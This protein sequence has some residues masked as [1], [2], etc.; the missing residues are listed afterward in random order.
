MR[1]LISSRQKLTLESSSHPVTLGHGQALLSVSSC[2]VCRTDAKMWRDGHRDLV[3]PRVPGHEL[4]GR[5]TTSGRRYVAWPGMVCGTC[6]YC[7]SGRENLCDEMRIIGFHLD[8]GFAAEVAV[9][10]Q[11][12]IPADLEVEDHLLTFAEPIACVL[13]GM[14]QLKPGDGDRLLIFG[15]GVVGM[16]A[17]LAGRRA[18]C[19][20]TVIERS[21]EKISRLTPFAR[22]NDIGLHKETNSSNFDLA[23]NCCDSHIAFS[24]LLTKVRK[25][26]RINFFSGLEKRQ[27]LE[28]T[29]LNLIHY[30]EL[31]VIGSYGPRR[32][33]M[34]T[35]LDCIAAWQQ[36]LPELIERVI[37]PAE[38]AD[39]LPH[40]LSGEAL[41]YI[42][43]IRQEDSVH[44]PKSVSSDHDT[45]ANRSRQPVKL[46]PFLDRL[47]A[48]VTPVD[49]AFLPP[50]QR[51]IDLKTK[52][53]GALGKLESLAVQLSV[54]QQTL[55]PVAERRCLF[56]FAGDHGI[57]EEGVSAFPSRVTLQMVENFL[58]GGA[59]INVFCRQ[60]GIDLNIVDMGVNGQLAPHPLLIDQKV[61]RGT[62]NFATG[63]AMTGSEA[64]AAVENGARAFLAKQAEAG[65]NVVGL[66][67]MGIGNTT[68]ATAVIC[69][70]TGLS[71]ERGVGRGTGVDDEGLRRKREV[72]ERALGLHRLDPNDGLAILSRLGGFEL[73]GIAGAVIAAAA[74]KCCVV[75]DGIISTAAGLIAYQLCP[76]VRGYLVA[77]HRSVEQ[78]QLAALEHMQLTPVLDLDLRLGEG[79]GAAIA[80]N[81]VE[82]ACRTMRE[83]A[84]FE[85]AGVDNRSQE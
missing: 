31:T 5:D 59:A 29:L 25:G 48:S 58:A 38:V 66:G 76:A 82:L 2:A 10:R 1:L 60:F 84:S 74:N 69:A 8:G 47:L 49:P 33:H 17:A 52:P 26:G 83:M 39:I 45:T 15:G 85:E 6:P 54:I 81:L 18:G 30:R 3:L 4:V 27:E 50:A 35:A 36:T 67:E 11:S 51:K 80:I 73:G 37:A 14:A 12:L 41:K 22:R 19:E 79:T 70:V 65:C 28:S 68:S 24:Q 32:D 20:V 16:L 53:L 42:V 62:A 34:V 77:G 78:G 56:V 13:H 21:M 46:S 64:L 57:V 71:V 61:G 44:Q 72:L 23:I 7:L 63:P 43:D 55:E 75:L 9:D 40:V